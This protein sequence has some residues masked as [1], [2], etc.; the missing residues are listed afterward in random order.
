MLQLSSKKAGRKQVSLSE[1]RHGDEAILDHLDLPAGDAQRMMELGFLPGSVIAVV[2]AAPG[3]D[4]R[5]YRVDGS[6]F[7]IRS[8]TAAR[9]KVRNS[10]D[11]V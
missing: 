2:K 10:M 6:E 3:G 9:M 4:P 5:V 8:E 1:L 7:A 11:I